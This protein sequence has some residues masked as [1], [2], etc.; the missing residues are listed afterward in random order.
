MESLRPTEKTYYGVDGCGHKNQD[1]RLTPCSD[2]TGPQLKSL[3]GLT[4]PEAELARTVNGWSHA[5]V[6]LVTE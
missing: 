4:R 3:T 2:V 6:S 5:S 1:A